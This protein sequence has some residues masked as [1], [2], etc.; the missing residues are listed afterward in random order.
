[1]ATRL[2]QDR[3]IEAVDI[4]LEWEATETDRIEQALCIAALDSGEKI[5][6]RFWNIRCKDATGK[7]F[8]G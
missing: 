4:D 1:M 2:R 3:E 8:Y 5:G 7:D 6:E